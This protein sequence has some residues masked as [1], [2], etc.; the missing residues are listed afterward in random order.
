MGLN[1][2]LIIGLS[3]AIII[4][5]IIIVIV[6]IS[7]KTAISS[8]TVS[9]VTPTIT[10]AGPTGPMT[11]PATVSVPAY[12]VSPVVSPQPVWAADNNISY[13]SG[14][15]TAP[16][17]AWPDAPLSA[18]GNDIYLGP[19]AS[20]DQCQAVCAA[21]PISQCS[22]YTWMNGN[23]A[24]NGPYANQCYGIKNNANIVKTPNNYAMSSTRSV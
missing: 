14:Q 19:A 18:D 4:V 8:P 3:A 10:V 15:L 5:G 7:N 9:S 17:G 20:Q 23:T 13:V 21:V 24:M 2:G 16:T 1:A 11:L 12:M 6:I 22:A